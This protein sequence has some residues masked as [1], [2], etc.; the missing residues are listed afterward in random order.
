MAEL[1]KF[2]NHGV[3]IT[4]EYCKAFTDTDNGLYMRRAGWG[5]QVKQHANTSN[6]FHFPI[7]CA[8][9]LDG[10]SA[11]TNCAYLKANINAS[12]VITRV[13]LTQISE[14]KL[15]SIPHMLVK[16][17]VNL[18]NKK[19]VFSFQYVDSLSV[20]ALVLSVFVQFKDRDAAIIFESAGVNVFEN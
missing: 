12:A 7:T 6:W 20:G 11:Y 4:P 8:S 19:D 5:T 2:W 10:D 1:F 13:H 17:A 14:H 9:R 15:S 3:Q 18:T 16:A